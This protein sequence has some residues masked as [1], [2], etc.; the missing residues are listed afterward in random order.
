VVPR[1]ENETDE[2][3]SERYY[4]RITEFIAKLNKGKAQGSGSC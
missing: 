4:K 3:Y 2:E 1:N